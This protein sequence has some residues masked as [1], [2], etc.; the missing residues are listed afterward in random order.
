MHKIQFLLIVLKLKPTPY[1][2]YVLWMSPPHSL[3]VLFQCH[4]IFFLSL[5]HLFT[6]NA[7]C[8]PSPSSVH[9]CSHDDS[10]AIPR[11]NI[12][13]PRQKR[14]YFCVNTGV[15]RQSTALAPGDDTVQLVVTHKGTPG[16]TLSNG[17]EGQV[18][19]VHIPRMHY[20]FFWLRWAVV[21]LY[22]TSVFTSF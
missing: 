17:G 1:L 10:L 9:S 13:D 6:S 14:A 5:S 3:C 2:F 15:V 21:C 8:G 7:F 20:S 11:Q 4:M 22:L 19:L 18:T 12:L 16:V